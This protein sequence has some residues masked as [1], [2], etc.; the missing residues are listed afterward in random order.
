MLNS[1]PGMKGHMVPGP[2]SGHCDSY[3]TTNPPRQSVWLLHALLFDF[4]PQQVK[5][6]RTLRTVW[7]AALP[8][9]ER[10][11]SGPAASRAGDWVFPLW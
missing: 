11:S 10:G 2:V 9:A 7:L 5:D 6:K 4:F 8:D 1:E 3:H